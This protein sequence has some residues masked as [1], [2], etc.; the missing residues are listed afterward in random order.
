LLD[1][2]ELP[3]EIPRDR[4]GSFEPHIVPKHPT[5]WTGFDNKIISLYARGMM[6]REAAVQLCI[7]YLV[8]IA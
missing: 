2:G 5:R 3:I 6:V 1:F 7:L 4:H 8:R